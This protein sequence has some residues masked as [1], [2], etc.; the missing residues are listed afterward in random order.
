MATKK[1]SD[2]YVKSLCTMI[3][4]GDILGI[5]ILMV[6]LEYIDFNTL[7]NM[8]YLEVDMLFGNSDI[9]KINPKYY[10]YVSENKKATEYA[11]IDLILYSCI[12]NNNYSYYKRKLLLDILELDFVDFSNISKTLQHV[13]STGNLEVFSILMKLNID[14]NLAHGCLRN[15]EEYSVYDNCL[16]LALSRLTISDN[17]SCYPKKILDYLT[18]IGRKDIDYSLMKTTKIIAETIVSTY[19]MEDVYESL[20]SN[21]DSKLLDDINLLVNNFRVSK[22]YN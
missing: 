11:P 22:I 14:W 4:R 7:I 1:Y 9:N 6:Y 5:D 18:D 20:N 13:V 10:G 12:Y 19:N 17:S 3:S 2:N 21:D 8:D 15:G 16:S